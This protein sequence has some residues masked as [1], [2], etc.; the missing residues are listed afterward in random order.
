MIIIIIIISTLVCKNMNFLQPAGSN[1]INFWV[2][3]GTQSVGPSY[4][5]VGKLTFDWNHFWRKM[6]SV[7]R[8]L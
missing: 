3:N 5:T 8:K 1:Q 7:L 2:Y 6:L 4:V